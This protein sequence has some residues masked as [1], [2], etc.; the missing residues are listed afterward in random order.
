M[1]LGPPAA[2][3]D[4]YG[5]I[6]YRLNYGKDL[7]GDLFHPVIS[8]DALEYAYVRNPSCGEIY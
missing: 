5:F 7:C 6:D 2:E 8:V 3:C 1:P 4:S